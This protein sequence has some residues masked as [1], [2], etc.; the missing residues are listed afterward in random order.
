MKRTILGLFAGIAA[1]S[2]FQ[3]S[4]AADMAIKAAPAV[5]PVTTSTGLYLG[6][7]GGAAWQAAFPRH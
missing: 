2:F 1:A 7:H 5:A 4:S 6:V 3:N